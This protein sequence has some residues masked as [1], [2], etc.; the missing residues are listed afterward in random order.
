MIPVH[1]AKQLIA[2]HA[3]P[4][5]PTDLLLQDISG[6]VLARDVKSVINVPPFNI[7]FLNSIAGLSA[8][9]TLPLNIH[10]QL[11]ILLPLTVV[12]GMAG[13]WL[14]ANRFN[15]PA[16]KYLLAAVMMIAASKFVFT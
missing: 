12:A 2:K 1:Q 4:S 14:G 9:V 7:I 16:L 5:E 3:K 8:S 15:I 11:E 10:N 6:S 13:A